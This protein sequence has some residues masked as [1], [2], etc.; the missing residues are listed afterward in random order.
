M[1]RTRR[2]ETPSPID[3]CDPRATRERKRL[4]GQCGA[5][6]DRLGRGPATNQEL[7]TI[8][9]KYTSRISDCRKSGFPIE[10]VS[11]DHKT[12]VTTYALT[13]QA[14]TKGSQS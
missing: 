9:L 7:A 4:S 5:I 10:V 6:L 2:N 11:R 3:F 12:G 1:R 13:K 8:A 14:S